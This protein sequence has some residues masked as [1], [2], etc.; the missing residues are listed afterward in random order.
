MLGTVQKLPLVW[1]V[2]EGGQRFCTKILGWHSFGGVADWAKIWKKNCG[3]ENWEGTEFEKNS[4]I[5]EKNMI[6]TKKMW[7]KIM[8]KNWGDAKM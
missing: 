1:L 7:A 4:Q 3:G 2:L 5:T 8:N 6:S